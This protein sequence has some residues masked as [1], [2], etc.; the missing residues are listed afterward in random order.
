VLTLT[1]RNTPVP[2][3]WPGEDRK[4]LQQPTVAEER[5]YRKQRLA[6]GFR[7]FARFGFEMGAAGH[8]TARDPEYPDHFWVNPLTLHFSTIRVSDLLLVD[9]T[10]RVVEGEGRLNRAAFAIH[11]AIHKVRPDVVAAAHSHSL[12]GKI[13]STLGRK[14]EPLSQDAAAFF[15]DHVLF[16]DF[17]GVVYDSSEG[18]RIAAAL[19]GSKAAILQNHGL[20]TVGAS[21]E[22][23]VW[24]YLSMENACKTQLLAESSGI[25]PRPMVA[26]VA[27]LT[28]QQIGSETGGLINFEPY[29]GL[30]LRDEPDFLD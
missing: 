1:A 17:T 24:W 21:V 16:N 3:L 9:H 28:R 13:W 8:I 20:L 12:Y 14:L 2:T 10:G 25:E 29:W 30:V 7:I 26:D 19:G 5:L 4:L 15:E 23:A 11:S 18:E 27:R 22:G 6:A